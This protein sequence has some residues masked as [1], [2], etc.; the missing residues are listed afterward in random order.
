M[1]GGAPKSSRVTSTMTVTGNGGT[2]SSSLASSVRYASGNKSP[3]VESGW[4][5]LMNMVPS[6]SAGTAQ[7][8]RARSIAGLVLDESILDHAD[9]VTGEDSQDFAVA[10]ALCYH[11]AIRLPSREDTAAVG[12]V[13]NTP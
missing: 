7:M 12:N 6:S 5:S 4:P 11:G 10:L 13:Q 3:R 9:A 1:S 2:S 8:L